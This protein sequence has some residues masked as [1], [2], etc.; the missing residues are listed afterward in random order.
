MRYFVAGFFTGVATVCLLLATREEPRV[1]FPDDS[2]GAGTWVCMERDAGP[3]LDC[4]SFERF[5]L[6]SLD[7]QNERQ[8]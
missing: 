4:F 8:R 7:K 3:A 6:Y 5:L 1:A 2:E